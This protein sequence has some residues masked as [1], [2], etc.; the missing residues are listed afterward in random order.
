MV[1][2]AKQGRSFKKYWREGRAF[3]VHFAGVGLMEKSL[4][5][6]KVAK[7][8]NITIFNEPTWK[9]RKFSGNLKFLA[10]TC[11]NNVFAQKII[12]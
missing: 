1:Y 11:L 10:I 6:F 2:F 5:F 12:N 9:G 8:S 4:K 3:C 7:N